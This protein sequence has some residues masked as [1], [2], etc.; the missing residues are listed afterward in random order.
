MEARRL[1]IADGSEEFTKALEEALRDSYDLQTCR[2]GVEALE[3][4]Q[5][6][7]PDVLVLDLMLPGL[8]GISLLESIAAAKLHPMVMATSRFVNDY[9]VESVARLGVAYM[10][11]KPCQIRAV[12]ERIADLSQRVRH[13]SVTGPDPKTTV[14]NILLAL[15]F[16]AKLRGYAYLREAAVIMA[17]KPE[18]SITKELYPAV[19]LLCKADASHVERS[20]RSAISTAWKKRDEAIWQMYLGCGVDRT[21]TRPTN[22]ELIFRLAEKL[23]EFR[24]HPANSWGKSGSSL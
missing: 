17:E 18:I 8:D 2:D 15:G 9:V 16:P 20:I 4:I 23:R 22:A 10:M 6:F 3:L 13:P 12:A 14:S 19:G 11:Q 24:E 5:T 1:V 7:R 21:L